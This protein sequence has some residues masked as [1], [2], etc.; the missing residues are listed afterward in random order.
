MRKLPPELP[1]FRV[2]DGR[3]N[4]LVKPGQ[5]APP[6]NG[7][8]ADGDGLRL[9]AD[10]DGPLR[11]DSEDGSL[12]GLVLPR[13]F[14][15]D[16]T[17]LLYLLDQP[18]QAEG[19]VVRRFDPEA[20]P[21]GPWFVPLPQVGGPGDPAEPRRFR[22]P[23][24]IA[25]SG[26][27]LYV[28]DT[29]NR[30]VQVFSLVGLALRAVW[31]PL[32]ALDVTAGPGAVYVLGA[33][34]VLRAVPGGEPRHWA[35]AP[36]GATAWSR[37]AV[38]R[39]GRVYVLG[40]AAAD[41]GPALW[42]FAPDGTPLPGGPVR[43]AGQVRDR[44]DPPPLRLLVVPPPRDGLFCLP[45]GLARPCGRQAPDPPPAPELPLGACAG[46][47]R[48]GRLFDRHGR[49]VA[50]DSASWP[51]PPLY[52]P[53]GTWVAPNAIDSTIYRCAWHR[54]EMEL[55]SLPPGGTVTVSAY[56][57]GDDLAYGDVASLPAERWRELYTVIG[58]LQ[59]RPTKAGQPALTTDFLIAGDPGRYLWLRLDLAGDRYG[60]PVVG[61]L[62]VHYP[63]QSYLQYLPAV[64]SEDPKGRDFLERFLSIFQT[65][66]DG[67]ERRAGD[68]AGLFD[69]KAVPERFLPWLAGWLGFPL[70]PTWTAAQNR[71]LLE[72][73]PSLY[74]APQAGG[75][76]ARRATPAE[77][78]DC[79]RAYLGAMAGAPLG[80]DGDLPALVEG[81]RERGRL[82]LSRRPGNELDNAD[83]LW[84]PDVVPRAQL[85]ADARF[86]EARLISTGDPGLDVFTAYAHRFRVVVPSCWVPTAGAEAVLRR[87]VAAEKP[88]HT[89]WELELLEPRL[90]VG[91][92][93]TLGLDTLLGDYPLAR[94]GPAAP[95]GPPGRA[96]R[97]VL[98]SDTVLAAADEPAAI[99][100][101][102]AARVGVDTVVA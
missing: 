74:A 7:V 2:V 61:G 53:A 95:G 19:A 81:F 45:D 33:Q 96:P 92:Q 63:R 79:L 47:G 50:L 90:R 99:R 35:E 60:S 54:V 27:G 31:G 6:P 55:A 29:G 24:N 39:D 49:P 69:P 9:A 73:A 36:D 17:E 38:D 11:L 51:R 97:G 28:A 22:A 25:I 56:A 52:L 82:L 46:G 89:A 20:G 30:R 34:E 94:L 14:A 48:A 8:V 75:G 4:W 72:L 68:V 37:I 102:P 10:P 32:D 41:G 88:A 67:L 12:G 18:G 16:A 85:D 44:F 66:W 98:G 1:T 80:H 93:S 3:N 40:V 21:D 83:P 5:S 65:T 13:G 78:I 26:G 62:R 58:D 59:P 43:D 64:Y 42:V 77:L 87:A 15:L 100:L 91:V 71:A 76:G 70:E 101:A 23:A 57:T 84:G 86:D